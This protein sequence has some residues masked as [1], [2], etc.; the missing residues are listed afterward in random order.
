VCNEEEALFMKHKERFLAAVN[1][2]EPDRVPID[3]WYTPEM[4]ERVLDESAG[5][6][7]EL[8]R[9]ESCPLA[10]A[11]G[12]DAIKTTIGPCTGFY[13]SDSEYYTDEWGIGWKRVRY[14]KDCYYT[15]PF[16]HP[17]ASAERLDDYEIPDFSD[18]SRYGEVKQLIQQYGDEYV[19]I[20][21]VACTLFELSWY[22]RGYQTVLMDLVKNK[23]FMHEYLAKLKQ[24]IQIAGAKLVRMGV[25]VIFLGDDFGMQDRMIISPAAFREFFKPIYAELFSEFRKINPEIKIAFHTDGNVEAIIPDFIEIGLDIL[26]PVQPQSMDPAKLKRQFGDRL[27]FWGTLDNQYTIPFGSPQEVADEVRTRLRTVAPRGGL[28]IGPAHNVQPNTPIEN[29]RALYRTVRE[30]G[31]YPIRL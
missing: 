4:T 9:S 12:H 23:E 6:V 19:I 14:G 11:L 29:L 7:V 18:E 5:L 8:H 25:D 16:D 1:H 30:E 24:W 3:V 27:T 15:E 26:N 20:A 31:A 28:I 22:L 17:L 13:L 21:E 2:E 10:V